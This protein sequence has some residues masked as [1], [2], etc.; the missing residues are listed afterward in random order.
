LG[1]GSADFGGWQWTLR[2]ARFWQ[3]YRIFGRLQS[4]QRA[5]RACRKVRNAS[6]H[7]PA[8]MRRDTVLGA[9]PAAEIATSLGVHG[10]YAGLRLPSQLVA[11]LYDRA[12]N[13]ACFTRPDDPERFLI[14]QVRKGRSPRGKPVATADVDIDINACAAMARVA[15]DPAL[16]E[17]VQHHLGYRP[18]HVATRLYWSP[19][20]PLSHRERRSNGQT[21]DYH[22]DIE[23]ANTLYVYFYLT[24]TDR[25]GGPH[26]VVS[27]SHRPKSLRLKWR[28]TRQPEDI[29]LEHYGHDKVVV[30]EGKA[31]FGFFE[32]PAC[33]HK[34]LPPQNSD[35]L[36]LQLRYS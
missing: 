20:S 26:V 12:Q 9:L 22:Y 10:Y 15:G 35:R 36:M 7:R 11:E 27:G 17:A 6:L 30:L 32:D 28:S 14:G 33:F 4:W 16:I 29:V 19:R 23:R 18:R 13:S 25:Q 8:W 31:G 5:M 34:V 2:H 3:A 24:D 1:N 21:I